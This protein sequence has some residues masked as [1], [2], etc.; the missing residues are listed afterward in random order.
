MTLSSTHTE[1]GRAGS[2][3]A[4][5]VFTPARHPGA[6]IAG[7][8][9]GLAL[10]G[11][12]VTA[13]RDIAVRAEWLDGQQWSLTAAEWIAELSW[14]DWMWPTAVGLVIVGLALAWTAVKPRRRSHLRLAAPDMWT[15]PGDLARRC[16]AAVTELPGVYDADT[17]VTRRKVKSTVQGRAALADRDLIAS[18]LADVVSV[19]ES[20]PRVVV[21]LRFRDGRRVR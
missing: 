11:L 10:I 13:I 7:A 14:Q 6:A 4:E 18:T 12:G 19:L 21:R 16:S 1:P 5:R 20:P 3:P 2:E 17:I 9:L 15:R 8:V